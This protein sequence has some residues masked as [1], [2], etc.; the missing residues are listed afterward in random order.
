MQHRQSRPADG[1]RPTVIVCGSVNTDTFVRVRAFPAPGETVIA[2]PAGTVGGGPVLGGKGANQ[3]VAAARFAAGSACCAGDGTVDDTGDD[4]AATVYLVATVG[5]DAAGAAA[6]D[7]LR[8]AGVDVSR[9]A[10]SQDTPTG[11]A[12]IMGD[13]EGENIIIVTSGANTL[14]DPAQ[15]PGPG[16]PTGEDATPA[17][18]VLLAQ[19]ELTPGHSAGLPDLAE[20]HGARF[21][22]NLAPVTVHGHDLQELVSTADPLIVNETEAADVLGVPRETGLDEVLDGLAAAVGRGLCRSAVVTLGARG[23]LVIDPRG[24]V[25]VES[26]A[27]AQVV[28]TTGAGDAFCGTLATALATGSGLREATRFAVAA[29]SLA[30]ESP[31][32]SASCADGAAVRERAGS[33]LS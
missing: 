22:L 32:A 28:D 30:V 4:R 12:F 20:R 14:T 13:A 5:E 25:A 3:A 19:G 6:L 9:V 31:G 18:D 23:A 33:Q 24:T 10:R 15:V 17:A 1:P 2:E 11:S 16:D 26:P 21:V 27:P 7:T 8:A 29:G